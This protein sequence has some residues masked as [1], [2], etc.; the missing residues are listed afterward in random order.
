MKGIIIFIGLIFILSSCNKVL[1]RCTP[2]KFEYTFQTNK[3]ID[4]VR[5]TYNDP[6]FEYYRY[7][8]N[9]GNN[10]V[11]DYTYFYED[12]PEIADDEGLRKIIFEVPP[13]TDYFRIEDSVNLKREKAIVALSCECMPAL[14]V[15]FKKGWIEGHRTDNNHWRISASLKEPWN[16]GGTINFDRTFTKN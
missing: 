9:N 6:Q 16:N 5:L 3:Q 7:Q 12:C 15:F 8:L 2:E 13:S 14:P 4:T 1:R 10:L 11:F